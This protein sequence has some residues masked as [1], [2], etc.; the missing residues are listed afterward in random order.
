MRRGCGLLSPRLR[1]LRRC[2]AAPGARHVVPR[3]R[4]LCVRIFHS[5][6]RLWESVGTAGL[7]VAA[8]ASFEGKSPASGN[9][10]RFN[11]WSNRTPV[12]TRYTLMSL[13][14][15]TVLS[16]I[17]GFGDWMSMCPYDA[18]IHVQGVWVR[19]DGKACARATSCRAVVTLQSG[20]SSRRPSSRTASCRF[21]SSY[22]GSA[23]LV[24]SGRRSTVRPTAVR[25]A[26][27]ACRSENS[28]VRTGS[29]GLLYL[30]LLITLVNNTVYGFFGLFLNYNPL[31]PMDLMMQ[32]SG[33]FWVRTAALSPWRCV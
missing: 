7:L 27:H 33:S 3:P 4:V 19:N 29:V 21:C 12:I 6:F 9:A 20:A 11:D 32:C 15:M 22:C 28:V 30:M 24:G 8:A 23:A 13:I 17:I 5:S 1:L 31:F 25:T 14:G 2:N 26:L 18:I 10:C 16:W